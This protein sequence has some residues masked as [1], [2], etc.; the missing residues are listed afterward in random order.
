[1]RDAIAWRALSRGLA[2]LTLVALVAFVYTRGN[3][4]APVERVVPNGIGAIDPATNTL[5]SSISV[6]S[7]PEHLAVG[8]GSVWVANAGDHTVSQS[9]RPL[10]ASHDDEGAHAARP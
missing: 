1:M 3:D 7:Y 8:E 6:G 5:V 9:R 4:A 10:R 2:A